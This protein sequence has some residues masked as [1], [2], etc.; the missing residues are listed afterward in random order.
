MISKKA[1][2]EM[3]VGTIVTI[4]LLMTI[5]ILGLVLV[6]TIFKTATTSIDG[7][8]DAM[9]SQ[10]QKLFAEDDNRKIVIQPANREV[11][12]KKGDEGRG[13]GLFI[14]N[15]G[16]T[17][18]FSYDL[19]AQETDCGLSLTEAEDLISLN[20]Q[21]KAI[22]IPGGNIMESGIL[23]KFKIPET[24]PPCLIAYSVAVELEGKPYTS[25]DVYVTIEG[26]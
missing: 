17:S 23:V 25:T 2:M 14:R 18:Q 13:F 12:L 7:I 22:T 19:T 20:K 10:V 9:R 24:V 26:K 15:V 11:S 6:R 16:E 3:S 21:R 1:A 5:L 4:V 8:D